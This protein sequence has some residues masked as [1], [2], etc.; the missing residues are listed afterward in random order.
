MAKMTKAQFM[1]MIAARKAQ[2]G[3]KKPKARFPLAKKY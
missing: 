2:K 3:A 1:K